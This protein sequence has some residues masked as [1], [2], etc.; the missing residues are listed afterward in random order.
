MQSVDADIKKKFQAV[1]YLISPA[2]KTHIHIHS[3]SVAGIHLPICPALFVLNSKSM[4]SKSIFQCT[5]HSSAH[6]QTLWK[7]FLFPLS[8]ALKLQFF[9]Y[10]F[11]S[12]R[13]RIIFMTCSPFFDLLNLFLIWSVYLVL[14]VRFT[15][16]DKSNDKS[17]SSMMKKKLKKVSRKIRNK[18]G[19]RIADGQMI[20]II[21]FDTQN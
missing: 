5:F 9:N 7:S 1:I 6:S 10:F 21:Q 16:I 17:L 14:V 19:M 18:M 15:L 20:I 2:H 13:T 12:N 8:L 3:D 11:E 4:R